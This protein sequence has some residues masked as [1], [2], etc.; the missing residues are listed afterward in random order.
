MQGPD[1]VQWHGF[2]EVAENFYTKLLPQAEAAARGDEKVLAVLKSIQESPLHSWRK[3]LS[4]ED[5]AKIDAFYKQRY[6]AN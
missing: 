1:F 5:R 2:F 6:G 3:G 4:P